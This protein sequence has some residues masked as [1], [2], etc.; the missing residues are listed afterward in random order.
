MTLQQS[1]A[2]LYPAIATAIKEQRAR[3]ARAL[4]TGGMRAFHLSGK[5]GYKYR[6]GQT[7]NKMRIRRALVVGVNFINGTAIAT[8]IINIHLSFVPRVAKST[9]IVAI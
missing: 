9:E 8:F 6:Q 1:G 5:A 3:R 7:N 2:F 4:A